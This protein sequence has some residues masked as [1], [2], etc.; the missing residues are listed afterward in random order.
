MHIYIYIIHMD[1]PTYIYIYLCMYADI[2]YS[3]VAGKQFLGSAP[4]PDW[5]MT[6]T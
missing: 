4:D 5:K 1:T 3:T 2:M 6:R